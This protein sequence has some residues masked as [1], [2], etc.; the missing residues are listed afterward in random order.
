MT[1]GSPPARR[2]FV[3]GVTGNIACGKS[4]VLQTLDGLGAQT[5]D[6][7]IVYHRLIEPELPLWETLVERFGTSILDA[8]RRIDRRALGAIVFSDDGALA[9][10]DRLTHPA[11]IE[12]VDRLISESTAQVVAVDAVKLIESGM[13]R[14]CDRVW[15][16]VCRPEQQIERLMARNNLPCEDA[17]HRVAAQPPLDAKIARAD[18]IVD[19]SGSFEATREQVKRAW[20]EL[21]IQSGY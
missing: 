6:A 15:L 11:V 14:S 9:D 20:R 17:E 8:D 7:D 19:N 16:V 4:L 3:I 5:I 13:D 21:P 10:L 18:L 1:N 2:P 12:A